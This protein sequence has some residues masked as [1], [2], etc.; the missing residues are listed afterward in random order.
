[1]NLISDEN[2]TLLQVYAWLC[3][4]LLV[5]DFV[6]SLAIGLTRFCCAFAFWPWFCYFLFLL[7]AWLT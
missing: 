1:M 5:V 2:I 3:V 7:L 4:S 6:V